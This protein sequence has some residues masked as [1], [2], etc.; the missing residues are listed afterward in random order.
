MTTPCGMHVTP[1]AKISF[2][3]D[4]EELLAEVEGIE[5]PF[6]V[7]LSAA[8]V[9]QLLHNSLLVPVFDAESNEVFFEP[10]LPKKKNWE[11]KESYPYLLERSIGYLIAMERSAMHLQIV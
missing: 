11:K 5:E 6:S 1:E 7:G 3:L 9:E 8:K 10:A 2:Y 4:S